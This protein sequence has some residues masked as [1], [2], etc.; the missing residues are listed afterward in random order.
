M[1]CSVKRCTNA[2]EEENIPDVIY[3]LFFFLSIDLNSAE[4]QLL[5]KNR[6]I[7]ILHY[8]VLPLTFYKT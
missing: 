4:M 2:V 1:H 6:S 3:I 5:W 8:F 7:S